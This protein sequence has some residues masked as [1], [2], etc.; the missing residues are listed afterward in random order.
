M[1]LVHEVLYRSKHFSGIEMSRYIDTLLASLLEAYGAEGRVKLEREVCD[2]RLGV[3][4]ASVLGLILN[5]LVSNSL[6]HAFAGGRGG[7]LRVSFKSDG[8]ERVLEVADDGPGLPEGLDL[9]EPK[10]LGLQLV[11]TLARQLS[12]YFEAAPGEGS[13][14][15]VRFRQ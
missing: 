11:S 3:D 15:R 1:A 9:R 7:R 5:E 12:G 4:Q 6:K 2:C 8:P 14:M 10:T 13:R